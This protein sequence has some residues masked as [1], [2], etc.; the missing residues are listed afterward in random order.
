MLISKTTRI[1]FYF[2]NKNKYLNNSEKGMAKNDMPGMS[3]QEGDKT[4]L[5]II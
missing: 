5:R 2:N 1:P 3:K 4:S